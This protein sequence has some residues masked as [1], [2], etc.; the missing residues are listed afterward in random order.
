MKRL[1]G[2][3]ADSWMLGVVIVFFALMTD[4]AHSVFQMLRGVR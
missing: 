3:L 2:F 4:C 1:M